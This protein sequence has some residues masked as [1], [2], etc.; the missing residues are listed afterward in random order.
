MQGNG[1][2]GLERDAYEFHRS[3][4]I[5]FAKCSSIHQETV[6]SAEDEVKSVTPSCG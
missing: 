1:F 3:T 4:F 5:H 2:Y 6:D